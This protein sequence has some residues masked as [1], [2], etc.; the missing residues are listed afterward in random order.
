MKLSDMKISYRI[1][2][3]ATICISGMLALVAI[4]AYEQSVRSSYQELITNARD[5]AHVTD[6]IEIDFLEARR[7]EKNFFLSKDEKSVEEHALIQERLEE[8]FGH[9]KEDFQASHFA[10]VNGKIPELHDKLK[11]YADVFA[12]SVAADRALGLDEQSGLRGTLLAAVRHLEGKLNEIGDPRLQ[13]MLLTLRRYEKDFMLRQD[14]EYIERVQKQAAEL[15][16]VDFLSF[17]SPE[18][19]DAVLKDLDVYTK[20]FAEYAET[21]ATEAALRKELSAVFAEVEPIFAVIQ[22]AVEEARLAA[23]AASEIGRAHV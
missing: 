13:V 20:S 5:T 18:A 15:A 23:D 14:V 11:R 17:G 12:Q 16:Q 8:D 9:L 21:T 4:F 19:R 3:I 1:G 2:I 10:V 22:K 7:L 6:R